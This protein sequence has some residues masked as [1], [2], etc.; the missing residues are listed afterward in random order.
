MKE[1]M[2]KIEEFCIEMY[3]NIEMYNRISLRNPY[4]LHM[5]KI[6]SRNIKNIFFTFYTGLCLSSSSKNLL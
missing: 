2:K 4:F 5:K 3:N 1:I 6:F